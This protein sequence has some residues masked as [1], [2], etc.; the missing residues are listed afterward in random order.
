MKWIDEKGFLFGR[1]NVIDF[2]VL[3]VLILAV[4]G[5]VYKMGFVNRLEEDTRP[6]DKAIITFMVK[7]VSQCTADVVEVGGEI[8]ELRSNQVFG[9]IVDK[10][11]QPYSEAASD[12]NGKWVLSE[13]PGKI[14]IIITVEA[15]APFSEDMKL[16]S[17]DAKVGSKIDLKG[18]KFAVESY[19]TGVQ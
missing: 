7:E 2:I 4:A 15:Y 18:P 13:V 3:L 17:K 19:I 9:K 1:I 14:N 6:R 8:K 16:G 10:E 12:Q 5:G 11:V